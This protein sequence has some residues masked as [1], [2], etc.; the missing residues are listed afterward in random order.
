MDAKA[1][2]CRLRWHF[3]SFVTLLSKCFSFFVPRLG[4]QKIMFPA[5]EMVQTGGTKVLII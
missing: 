1:F 5:K 3:S 2:I 4:E